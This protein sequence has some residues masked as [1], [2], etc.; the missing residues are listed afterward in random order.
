MTGSGFQHL[1]SS[2]GRFFSRIFGFLMLSVAILALIFEG[3]CGKREPDIKELR[4]ITHD[5]VTA[6]QKV[7]GRKS[8]ITIRPEMGTTDSGQRGHLVADNIYITLGDAAQVAALEQALDEVA[9]RH[10]L[11]RARNSSAGGELRFDYELEG[12]RTH[13]IHIATS[14]TEGA[15]QLEAPTSPSGARLAI[16]ID[17][18]GYDGSAADAVL[19]LPAPLTVA[20]LP[21]HPLSSQIAEEAHRRGDQVILHLPMQSEGNSESNAEG[22]GAVEESELR[23]GMTP[24]QVE[25]ALDGM[26]ETVPHAAGA[27]NHQGSRA[28]ADAGLMD[29]VMR[30]L[31]RRGMFFID[32]R[33]TVQTVAYDTAERDG[34]PAAFRR[35]FLDDTPRR[36]AVL[37]QIELA[38][39]DAKQLG[40]AIAIGHPHPATIAA[41]NEELPRLQTGGIR[42]VFA[43][44]LAH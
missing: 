13:T 26:L 29:T 3:G 18:L 35:V 12:H 19:A 41:L 34:V 24:Q 33:T 6:A 25:R 10:H 16:I 43:S 42:L 32:S 21:H 1:E 37:R 2:S 31:A 5:F 20:V 39:R 36:E 11:S 23:V 44:E 40:W 4:A 14:K 22:N 30:A 17:D 38:A 8:E 7:V 15:S 27:N 9:R 28:T